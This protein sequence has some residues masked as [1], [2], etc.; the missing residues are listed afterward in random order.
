L[1]P[2]A[3]KIQLFNRYRFPG[4]SGLRKGPN[5]VSRAS[6]PIADRASNSAAAKAALNEVPFST[7]VRAPG[8]TVYPLDAT[9]A[10]IAGAATRRRTRNERDADADPPG[11]R[12][13]PRSLRIRY[14]A[15]QPRPR[16]PRPVASHAVLRDSPSSAELCSKP[17]GGSAFRRFA[18]R[19]QLGQT[20][21]RSLGGGARSASRYVLNPARQR[22]AQREDQVRAATRFGQR[23]PWMRLPR[24]GHPSATRSSAA[25]WCSER[26]SRRHRRSDPVRRS[27][28]PRPARVPVSRID[29]FALG[30]GVNLRPSG[31]WSAVRN[32]QRHGGRIRPTE[33]DLTLAVVPRWVAKVRH[34]AS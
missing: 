6:K 17:I 7:I 13:T 34:S 22:L 1:A 23:V 32:G 15:G 5:P 16:I 9:R 31:R 11:L 19:G 18:E 25:A 21:C 12:H 3:G 8:S 10:H 28:N 20:I 14:L 30:D 26:A 27:R 33:A 2:L 29:A 24:T 4:L